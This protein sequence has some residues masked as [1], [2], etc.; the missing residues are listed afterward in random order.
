MDITVPI[1][2][3]Q[4]QE[5]Q[6]VAKE[7][8]E[9]TWNGSYEDFATYIMTANIKTYI[10]SQRKKQGKKRKRALADYEEHLRQE[11]KP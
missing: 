1:S 8:V 5:F 3:A 2:D 7:S 4:W 6:E 11:R 10:E 9:A